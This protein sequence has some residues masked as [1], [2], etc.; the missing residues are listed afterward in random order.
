L[1]DLQ[2]ARR[3]EELGGR[4]ETFDDAL[5]KVDPE[6]PSA[7]RSSAVGASSV[8][9]PSDG[10]YFSAEG[11][12]DGSPSAELPDLASRIAKDT[13]GEAAAREAGDDSVEPLLVDGVC[14]KVCSLTTE[15]GRQAHIRLT[16]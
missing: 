8:Y 7:P 9:I 4:N 12:Q 16:A 6:P 1:D 14:A 5:E 3:Y 13:L 10:A 11:E 2:Q 15:G